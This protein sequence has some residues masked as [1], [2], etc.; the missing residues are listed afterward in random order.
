MPTV[1]AHGPIVGLALTR[2]DPGGQRLDLGVGI[3]ESQGRT[4]SGPGFEWRPYISPRF[5]APACAEIPQKVPIT[6]TPVGFGFSFW[7]S[8]LAPG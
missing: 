8:K 6:I 4:P 2:S 3:V 5:G 7:K 1:S